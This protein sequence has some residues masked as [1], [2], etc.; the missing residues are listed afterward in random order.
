MFHTISDAM[1]ERMAKLAAMDRGEL[2][3]PPPGRL[4]SVPAETG[5]FLALL[6]AAAPEGKCIEIGASG[7]YSGLWLS[8]AMKERGEKLTTYEIDPARALVAYESYRAAGCSEQ[9]ELVIGDAKKRLADEIDPNKPPDIAFCFL[10]AEKADYGEFYGMI[11]PRL[12]KRGI[13]AADNAISHRD[14]MEEFLAEVDEDVRVDSLVV[15]IGSGVLV[16]RK[17]G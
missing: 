14:E 13:L 12:V 3:A 9:V 1:K 7:G 11:V 17:C 6:A 4:W 15:P 10:D 16:C 2:P 8:L 5:R